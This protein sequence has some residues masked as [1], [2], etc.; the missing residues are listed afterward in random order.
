[1]TKRAAH[2]FTMIELVITMAVVAILTAIALPAY[3]QYVQRS[4]RSDARLALMRAAQ[5][6]E[7]YRTE[8]GTYRNA[9]NLPTLPSDMAVSP[10]PGNGKT[11]YS[12]SLV[13][14]ATTFT[15]TATRSTSGM[16]VTD[17]CGNLTLTHN[18]LRGRTGT[19]PLEQCW[20]R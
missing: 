5:W 8:W 11:Q 14:A 2:G 7:R 6:M 3:T 13:S 9:T 17:S 1:M 10:A 19:A 20:M 15:L 4:H 12:I 18:G 16:M